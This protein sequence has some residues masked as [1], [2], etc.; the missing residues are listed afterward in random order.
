MRIT[1][2]INGK[3]GVA[4]TSTA[5]AL[6]SGLNRRGYRALAIDYDRQGNLS[7]AYG[8]DVSGSPTMYHVINGEIAMADAIQRTPQGDIIA[9]NASLIR[10][11]ALY[12]GANYLK[13]IKQLQ[14]Q[15][16]LLPQGGEGAY[17][18]VIIDNAP[19]IGG[20]MALQSLVAATDIVIPMTAEA[21]SA[22]GVTD[23]MEAYETVQEDFNPGI[24]IA[25]ILIAR[26]NPRTLVSGKI[27]E[28]LDAWAQLHGTHIY[29][30]YIREGVSV[31]ESQLVSESLFDYAPRSKPALDYAS[32]V[33]EYLQEEA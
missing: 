15:L 20:L 28:D 13:G 30:A 1:S 7:L 25:G 29:E 4:K 26:Y 19:N 9:G 23:L 5:H 10:M 16:A 3:G 22:Q 32:F 8:V 17:T 11:D 6:A 21:F 18:H 24:R 33:S 12:A 14:R 2:I 31:K 27:R